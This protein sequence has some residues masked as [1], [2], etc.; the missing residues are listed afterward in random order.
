MSGRRAR[1]A[2]AGT[3]PRRAEPGR[4]KAGLGGLARRIGLVL[5]PLSESLAPGWGVEDARVAL[6]V[7]RCVDPLAA[8]SGSSCCSSSP[9]RHRLRSRRRPPLPPRGPG[10]WGANGDGGAAA[11]AAVLAAVAV[12]LAPLP[13]FQRLLHCAS[14]IYIFRGWAL[15]NATRLPRRGEGAGGEPGG[16]RDRSVGAERRAPPAPTPDLVASSCFPGSAECAPRSRR[17]PKA[18]SPRSAGPPSGGCVS[19][20]MT[21]P[22]GKK[23]E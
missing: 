2:G 22:G 15:P 6:E 21:K 17:V 23:Y 10:G 19:V 4:R 1:G 20:S 8:R 11:A 13:P 5:R 3:P 9:L 14:M 18:L 12:G 16:G 7:P